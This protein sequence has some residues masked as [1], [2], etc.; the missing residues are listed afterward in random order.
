MSCH[1][2]Y[3]IRTVHKNVGVFIKKKNLLFY[4]KKIYEA[5]YNTPGSKFI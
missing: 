3:N 2:D 1:D 4:I 5:V